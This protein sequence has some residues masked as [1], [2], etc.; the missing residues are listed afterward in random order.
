MDVSV[1]Q[2]SDLV[3]VYTVTVPAEEV[4]R[5]VLK[6]LKAAQRTHRQ[7]GFRPGRVPMRI[8]RGRFGPAVQA[9]VAERLINKTMG[10]VI[11]EAEGLV[12]VGNPALKS[13]DIE[14]DGLSYSFQ[15]EKLPELEPV[16]YFDVDVERP[17]SEVTDEEVAEALE[18]VRQDNAF[19][20]PVDGRE[21]VEEGDIVR[22]DYAIEEIDGEAPEEAMEATDVEV[23][24]GAGELLE[25]L[26]QGLIGATVGEAKRI[27]LTMPAL[28]EGGE[29]SPAVASATVHG[30]F[31]RFVPELDD[32]L[33]KD[34][35]RA[36]TLE[37][38]RGVLRAEMEKERQARSR[39]V[40]ANNLL[41][42]LLE[43]NAVEL[44]P[45]FLDARVEEELKRRFQMFLGPNGSL[46]QL[47]IDLTPMKDEMRPQ[48]ERGIKQSLLLEAIA[49][50]EE[51]EATDEDLQARVDEEI[52]A[53]DE[54]RQEAYRRH[55]ERKEAREQLRFS[56]RMDNTI[57]LLLEKANITEVDFVEHDHSHDHGG[58]GHEHSHD[59][60][61]EGHEH[62]HAHA[63]AGEEHSHD[64]D[65]GEG[66]EHSHDHDGEGHEHGHDHGDE[67]D[68]QEG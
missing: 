68:A 4:S 19:N 57:D 9:Q 35:G 15:A 26:E 50:K 62:A 49:D 46:E 41:G 47:G 67:G 48:V 27:E 65:H 33:A 28:E 36:E 51:V 40:A 55:Y 53:Q 13:R 32:E 5:E 63:H 34:D 61:D 59:H 44:P 2:S 54:H 39:N 66:H 22:L 29:G 21:V 8:I 12:H 42:A 60:D 7:R 20:E 31:K 52:A 14:K 6:E 56:V 45:G 30:I 11:R 3:M 64:H 24:L 18:A 25:G 43:Y 10:D 23:T 38:L 58:E 17:R 1:E 37:E 16:N